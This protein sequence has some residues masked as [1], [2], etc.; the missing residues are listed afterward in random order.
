MALSNGT[1]VA[2]R[3]TTQPTTFPLLRRNKHC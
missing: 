2:D 3:L 1:K